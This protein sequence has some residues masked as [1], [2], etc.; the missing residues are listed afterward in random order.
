[1]LDEV[2][3]CLR[4]AGVKGGRKGRCSGYRATKTGQADG[5]V[6]INVLLTNLSD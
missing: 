4:Q 3:A 5:I 1:M 6:T 2:W